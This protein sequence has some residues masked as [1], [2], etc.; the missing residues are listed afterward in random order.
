MTIPVSH[1]I[2]MD[3]TQS[4]TDSV[5]AFSSHTSGMTVPVNHNRY[6]HCLSHTTSVITYILDLEFIS[7]VIAKPL[8]FML[9]EKKV[10]LMGS[11]AHTFKKLGCNILD[12]ISCCFKGS[13]W[14]NAWLSN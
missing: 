11:N 5:N 12:T 6:D 13:V 1:T 8:G 10:S 2:G 3:K 4:H 9:P 7:N 14:D